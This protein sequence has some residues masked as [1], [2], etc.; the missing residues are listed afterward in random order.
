MKIQVFTI[1]NFVR[2]QYNI[3][4]LFPNEKQYVD[5]PITTIIFKN[6]T[7]F[8]RALYFCYPALA[9]SPKNRALLLCNPNN[10]SCACTLTTSVYNIHSSMYVI[11]IV[12]PNLHVYMMY[13]S[14]KMSWTWEFVKLCDEWLIITYSEC[15]CIRHIIS[16]HEYL[17]E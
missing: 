5:S 10:I 2:F 17:L 1:L 4:Q 16:G 3:Q 6:N 9:Y 14:I 7:N 13:V 8:K 11:V 12:T 15:A